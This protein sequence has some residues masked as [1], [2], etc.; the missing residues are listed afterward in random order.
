MRMRILQSAI[1]GLAATAVFSAAL[2]GAGTAAAVPVVSVVA[3]GLNSPRY[4]TFG[5]GGDL[6]LAVAGDG[7]NTRLQCQ[8]GLSARD[9]VTQFC[10]GSSSAVDKITLTGHNTPLLKLLGSVRETDTGEVTGVNAVAF[11]GGHPVVLFGNLQSDA[12]GQSP[13]GTGAF[14][15]LEHLST[16]RDGTAQKSISAFAATHPQS[17]ATLG[18]LP[19]ETVYDSDPHDLVPYRGGYAVADAGANDVLLVSATARV[20]IAARLPT[21]DETAPAGALGPGSPAQTIAAQAVPSSVTVGPDG[22]LYVGVL[23]G[24]PGLPGSAAVYRIVPGQAPVAVVTGLTRVSDLAFTRAGN[25]LILENNTGGALASPSTPGALLSATLD[26]TTPVDGDKSRRTRARR[27]DRPGGQRERRRLHH[28]PRVRGTPGRDHQGQRA[29]SRLVDIL[30]PGGG[31]RGGSSGGNAGRSSSIT[32]MSDGSPDG[33][34]VG[35]PGLVG[36]Q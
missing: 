28:Q 31:R 25:L 18:G 11:H 17:P 32:A 35:H 33:A 23:R 13:F 3:K 21:V 2:I 36:A 14:G 19:G 5:P 22:A 10:V 27:P 15:Y 12:L 16:S 7:S 20:S 29:L 8:P 9:V 1:A 26:G 24:L 4:L 30:L 34:A 6:Y